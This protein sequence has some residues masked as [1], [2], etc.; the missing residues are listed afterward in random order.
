MN[1]FTPPTEYRNQFSPLVHRH[2][3]LQPRDDPAPDCPRQCDPL[4]YSTVLQLP[5]SNSSN[6]FGHGGYHDGGQ[7]MGAAFASNS[8]SMS[9]P[10]PMQLD[11]WGAVA[12]PSGSNDSSHNRRSSLSSTLD[13]MTSHSSSPVSRFASQASNSH[14]AISDFPSDRFA[15]S[16]HDEKNATRT[17]PQF[18]LSRS[19]KPYSP[20]TKIGSTL[21]EMAYPVTIPGPDKGMRVDRNYWNAPDFSADYGRSYPASAASSIAG[22]SPPTPTV[23]E[24]D[25]FEARRNST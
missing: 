9:L 16:R 25:Q 1:S 18:Q 24:A 13:A 7:R 10:D 3:T 17:G 22:D 20:L 4:D 2:Q 11:D 15:A 23:G 8:L 19:L 12:Q 14:L 5:N 6:I 21:P